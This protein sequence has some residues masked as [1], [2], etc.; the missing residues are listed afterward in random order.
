MKK[1]LLTAL[2]GFIVFGSVS[3]TSA[4][5]APSETVKTFY[6]WYINESKAGK[7]PLENK[8]VIS[9]YVS[10][11][12]RNW[13]KTKSFKH[14]EAEYFVNAQ[15]FDASSGYKVITSKPVIKGNTAKMKV[16]LTLDETTDSGLSLIHI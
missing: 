9:K 11:R 3:Y 16:N 8:P 2:L 5:T 4:Q 14:Y 1:I 7:Q 15:D 12:L 10:K 13:F 6:E